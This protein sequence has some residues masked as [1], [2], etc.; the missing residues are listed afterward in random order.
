MSDFDQRNQNVHNQ[1]NQIIHQQIIFNNGVV[2]DELVEK[3]VENIVALL[4]LQADPQVKKSLIIQVILNCASTGQLPLSSQDTLAILAKLN[5]LSLEEFNR[6]VSSDNKYK[7]LKNRLGWFVLGGTAVGAGAGIGVTA[8]HYERV[9]QD[10]KT[11]DE[12]YN[13]PSGGRDPSAPSDLG[14]KNNL[15]SSPRKNSDDSF[16][17]RSPPFP[18]GGSSNPHQGQ[19]ANNVLER[20][21]ERNA[22]QDAERIIGSTV[23]LGGIAGASSS[24][25][26]LS[27]G[28][29]EDC[30]DCGDCDPSC[31][32]FIA[33]AVYGD[34]NAPQ[35]AS[36][37][38][39]RDEKL[40]LNPG[41]YLLV[42]IYYQFSPPLAQYLQKKPYFAAPIRYLLNKL[43]AWL[44]R[45]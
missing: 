31:D 32:C 40:I 41:G 30:G 13:P 37:R 18:G 34:P 23:G 29:S 8:A 14:E 21:I 1:V 22:G 4:P 36:L 15:E 35:V 6:L 10:L 26:Q 5:N 11:N 3:F 2:N 39:F 9:I 7:K 17:K 44:A 20:D 27:G 42:K 28:S 19:P 12:L 25:P 16:L 45:N 43:V 38:R 24:E 33:T